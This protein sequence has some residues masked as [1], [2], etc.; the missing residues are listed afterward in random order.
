MWNLSKRMS[1]YKIVADV[2]RRGIL[3]ML[4]KREKWIPNSLS[5]R[6]RN[7]FLFPFPQQGRIPSIHTK[8]HILHSDIYEVQKHEAK[9]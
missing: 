8:V 1:E 3:T 9:V 4:L 5:L 7:P 6:Q 2:F